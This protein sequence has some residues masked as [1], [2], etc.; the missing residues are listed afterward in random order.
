[1]KSFIELR[2]LGKAL[3]AL[4]WRYKTTH[5]AFL[6]NYANKMSEV[7]ELSPM[8][9]ERLLVDLIDYALEYGNARQTELPTSP[10]IHFFDKDLP[11]EEVAAPHQRFI[12]IVMDLV[13]SHKLVPEHENFCL[14]A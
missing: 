13:A 7:N 2:E 10:A 9:R 4:G 1:M 6:T 8:E 5:P 3:I 12:S 14:A 11:E